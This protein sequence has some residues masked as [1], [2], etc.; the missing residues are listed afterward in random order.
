MKKVFIIQC[1]FAAMLMMACSGNGASHSNSSTNPRDSVVVPEGYSGEDSIAYI[2]NTILKSPISAEDL[3][4]LAEVHSVEEQLFNYNNLEK[5]KENPEFADEYLPTHRDSA[6]MRLA[7]RL[8]RMANL[9][10]MNG[11]AN[12][13][14]QWAIAVNEAID[15]FHKEVPSV[16]SDSVLGEISRVVDKFSSQ[17]QSEMNFQ[18]YVD[19]TVEYYRT[20][21]AYRNWINAVPN[22]LKTL[23]QEEYKAWHDL[24]EARLAFWR[25]VSYNQEWYS[26]KPMEIEGYYENLSKNRRA[27]LEAENDVVLKGKPY[28]QKGKTV[29]T[30][31]WEEWIAKNSVPE[32][33]ELLHEMGKNENIPSDSLVADHVGTLKSAF[34]R[35]IKARQDIAAALPKALGDSYDNL[36]A[37]MHS[38]LIGKLEDIISYESY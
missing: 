30:S 6:A 4:G 16:P 38:R 11:D 10:N 20:I 17:T 35:W 8:M 3:L 14:L 19:A 18:C 29:T 7:N 31:Q 2:E 28:R 36:T 1:L 22:N 27:E 9:V 25:D 32:D 33:I 13:K 37:D 26:M 5:A 15:I 12:D 21:E 24:N 23:A 34:S